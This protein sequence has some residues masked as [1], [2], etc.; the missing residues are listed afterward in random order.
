MLKKKKIRTM[1]V[2]KQNVEE[3]G[4]NAKKKSD[5]MFIYTYDIKICK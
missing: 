5:H 1:Q 4:K 2:Y 3:Y